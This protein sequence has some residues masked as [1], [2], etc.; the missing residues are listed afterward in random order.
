MVLGDQPADQRARHVA[1]AEERDFQ[2]AL[3]CMSREPTLLMPNIAVPMRTM[4]EPSAIARSMSSL[5]PIDRVSS[6]NRAFRS[7]NRTFTSWKRARGAPGSGIAMRPRNRVFF[8]SA[9]TEASAAAAAGAI[10]D[11]DS[12]PE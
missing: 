12:S 6:A 1:A 8:I 9:I 10:P 4:V 11:F 7:S 5:I 2:A 3:L